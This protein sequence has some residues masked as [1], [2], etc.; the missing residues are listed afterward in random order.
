MRQRRVAVTCREHLALLGEPE[1]PAD[2]ARWL[3]P[4]GAPGGAAAPGHGPAAPVEEGERHSSSG[5]DPDDLFLSAIECP[6]RREVAAVLVAVRVP[7]HHRLLP[8]R[9][10][11]VL[12]VE[13]KAEEVVQDARGGVQIVQGLE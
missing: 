5:A 1:A 2:G 13:G 6:V 9:P 3:G 8:A 7:D 4:D 11:E 12:A 10:R